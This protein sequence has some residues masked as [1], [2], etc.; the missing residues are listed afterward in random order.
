MN[1]AAV[2]IRAEELREDP[3]VRLVFSDR[4]VGNVSRVVGSGDV[5]AARS[6]LFALVGASQADGVFMEQVHGAGVVTVGGA[7]RGRGVLRAD[8]AIEGADALV[9]HDTD[10]ALVVLVADCV[11]VLIV[12]PG[13]AVAAVHAGRRGVVGGVVGA[14]VQAIGG[15]PAGLVAVLGPAI[16]GCCYEVP[17]EL[18]E[19]VARLVPAARSRTRWGTPSLDLVAAVTHLLAAADVG[20]VRSRGSCTRC[21]ADRWFSHRGDS[22]ATRGRQAGVVCRGTDRRRSRLPGPDHGVA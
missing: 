1:Q 9:T 19:D 11:P 17:A 3:A 13:R 22:P 4:T 7:E 14:A 5:S 8:E 20:T 16:G 10:V 15:D 6:R 18:A 21:H 12:D 2:Q